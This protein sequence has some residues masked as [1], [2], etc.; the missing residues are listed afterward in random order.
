MPNKFAALA[1]AAGLS[2][3]GLVNAAPVAAAP[4][5]ALNATQCAAAGG[6]F[7]SQGSTNT[8]T[9]ETDETITTYVGNSERGWT[10]TTSTTTVYTRTTGGGPVQESTESESTVEECLNPGDQ[11]MDV[12]L[13]KCQP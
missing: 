8:C 4:F 5:P 1:A 13:I 7:T 12:D 6:T 3:V 2:I 9:V 11:S 10:V